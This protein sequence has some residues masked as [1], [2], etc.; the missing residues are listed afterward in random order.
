[1][2]KAGLSFPSLHD[3]N[4]GEQHVQLALDSPGDK[5]LTSAIFMPSLLWESGTTPDSS[6]ASLQSCM[7][8]GHI[9][10]AHHF[11][12]WSIVGFACALA[13]TKHMQAGSVSSTLF[14]HL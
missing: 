14:P 4:C 10:T 7:C 13:H 6:P 2:P 3:S 1:M 5:G 9:P 12:S 8:S 11:L